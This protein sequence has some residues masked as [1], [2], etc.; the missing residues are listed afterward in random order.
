MVVYYTTVICQKIDKRNIKMISK[1]EDGKQLELEFIIPRF[2]SK[3]MIWR[4]VHQI[5]REFHKEGFYISGS[6]I[7]SALSME[8]ENIPYVYY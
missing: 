1:N 2:K 5:K 7:S 3:R 6:Q 4:F 8:Y